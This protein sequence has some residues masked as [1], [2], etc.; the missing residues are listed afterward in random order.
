MKI[1]GIIPAR[2]GSK[3]LP[4]KN[5]LKIGGKTLVELSI[6][7]AFQSKLLTRTILSSDDDEIISIGKNLNCEVPFKRPKKLAQDKSSTFSVLNHTVNWLKKNEGWKPDILVLLQPT[8]PFRRGHH[9]DGVLK[10]LNDSK[11]DAVITIR[12]PS[13]P[14]HWMLRKDDSQK[15]FSLIK[16][17]NKFL[18]RQDTPEIYQPAGMVYAFNTDLLKNINTLFPVKD[19]RGF[20]VS[21]NESINIDSHI[22]YLT[23]KMIYKEKLHLL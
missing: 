11:S 21:Q 7:S 9:I 15:I 12:K 8:T 19:T 10:L 17:G 20:F 14:P 1:L 3:E 23:A 5:L 22:D 18:R 16:N 4:K 13:Y 2:G 6:E